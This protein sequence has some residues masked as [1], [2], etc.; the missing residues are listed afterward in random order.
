MIQNIPKMLAL[1]D[2]GVEQEFECSMGLAPVL[3]PES[4]K[5]HLAL[6]VLDIDHGWHAGDMFLPD[7]PSALQNILFLIADNGLV[8]LAVLTGGNRIY[9]A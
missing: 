4:D 6:A 1:A 9:L 8:Q 2:H 3:G 7:E 5:N